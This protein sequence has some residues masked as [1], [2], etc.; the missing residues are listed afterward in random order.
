MSGELTMLTMLAITA[1]AS[2]YVAWPL[3]MGRTRAEDFLGSEADETLLQRLMFQRDTTYSAMK[4]LEFDAAM[5]SLTEEDFQQLQARY[6]RKAVAILKRIDDVKAGRPSSK[7][8]LAEVEDEPQWTRETTH[9][10]RLSSGDRDLDV[11]QEI[12]AYRSRSRGQPGT[13]ASAARAAACPACG[14]PVADEDA[15][16]CGR[17]GETLQPGGT[18]ARSSQGRAERQQAPRGQRRQ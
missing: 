10:E 14:H 11:E 3:L 4:E 1:G 18:R 12:E 7:Q 15:R 2:V 5:G 16:F 8:V 17:C 13:G 6:K 9:P